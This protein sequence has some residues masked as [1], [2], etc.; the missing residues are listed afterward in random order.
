[1]STPVLANPN[2]SSAPIVT[3]H[4]R[5]SAAKSMVEG[6]KESN[7]FF[8]A[9]E[10]K[11]TIASSTGGDGPRMPPNRG[12]FFVGSPPFSAT[13]AAQQSPLPREDEDKDTKF[14]RANDAVQQNIPK[15]TPQLPLMNEKTIDN[16]IVKA[17]HLQ[18][19]TTDRINRATPPPSPSKSQGP[20][21]T[22]P[23]SPRKHVPLNKDISPPSK[24]R[25]SLENAKVT[26][27]HA[28]HGPTTIQTG[29]RK[30]TS[31]GSLVA[32]SER[33]T[34]GSR[35]QF[36]HPLELRSTP[37]AS[38]HMVAS[39]LLSPEA[40]SPRSISL[41]S[42]NTVPTSVT[43]DTDVSDVSKPPPL[44]TNFS[45]QPPD[46]I[47]SPSHS[48]T[49]GAANARRERKVLD[50]EISNSS[51]L[52]INKTLEREL[53][54]QSVE[55]RRFR[56]LSRSGRLSMVPTARSISGQSNLSL[57]TVTEF[58]D[59]DH[60]FSEGEEDSDPDDLDDED[61]SLLSNESGSLVS[62]SARSRQR[63]RDEKRLM[64]D[65]SKHQ[66]LLIDS[67]KLSQSIKRCMTCTEELIRDGS[68]ALDYRVGIGDVKLGGRVLNDEELDERG[69]QNGDD[70][71]QARQGLLSP[72]LAK[73]ELSEA[74][75]WALGT[76]I[77]HSKDG[78]FPA[79]EQMTELLKEAAIV[80]GDPPD[81]SG[82]QDLN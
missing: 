55:L 33:R 23:T 56:R 45:D 6:A 70:E 52:A 50:L 15:R 53:R 28:V 36:T 67:Q 3:V 42:S 7:K 71:V 25:S 75:T 49:D 40:L 12:H 65:L 1:M 26:S 8:H 66:Q 73:S 79:L 5:V 18:E 34:S 41:A 30:S 58:G 21:P 2:A 14:F 57:G 62:Q 74:Q 32:K 39:S 35:A 81:F 37:A 13:S 60:E 4:R 76:S 29:H 38:P 68:K 22:Q 72:T 48:H 24:S 77:G 10:V 63:A 16:S 51:L 43:S 54:K 69:F 11:S 80:L 31:A 61:D 9:S 64:L 20:L 27:A 46:L 78:G 17:L 47:T 19:T 44:L 82:G 59:E